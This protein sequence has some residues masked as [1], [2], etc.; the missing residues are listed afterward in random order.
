M[1]PDDLLRPEVHATGDPYR[2]WR[3]MR[4][5]D[6]VHRHPPGVHPGFWSLTRYHD[7]RTV[8]ADP[9][10]FSSAHGVLLRP[11]A[12]GPD[13]GGGATLALTDPPRHRVLRTLLAPPFAER[14]ARTLADVL[15]ARTGQLLEAAVER[16]ACDFTQDIAARLSS[17]VICTLLGVPAADH[18][19]VFAAT[20]ETFAADRPL[21]A[22]PRLIGF[23]A[24]LMFARMEQSTDDLLGRLVDGT[25]DG[26]PLTEEEILL[27]VENLVGATE[28]AGLSL[29]AGVQALTEHPNQWARVQRNPD[30]VPSAVEEMLRWGSSATHSLRTVTTPVTLHGRRLER[31][32]QVVVWIPSANRDETVLP[33]ADRF[34]VGRRPNRHLALGFGVHVCV[35]AVMFRTHARILL[36]ELLDRGLRIE[37]VAP[38]TQRRSIAVGGPEHLPV[39]VVPP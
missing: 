20:A 39:R 32:D 38:P 10:T 3:W 26:A 2:L 24:D 25:P 12:L 34:D 7:V 13:P 30:L 19:A 37:P 31:G 6:P 23:F 33:D 17:A 36:E 21:T 29:A 9:A 14:S 5:N 11:T 28:N 35:G 8:Y 16:Q 27:N 18:D 22:S 15:R 1:N 4:A